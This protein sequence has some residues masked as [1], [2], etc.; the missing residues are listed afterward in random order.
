MFFFFFGGKG[1][2]PKITWDNSGSQGF[3]YGF[4]AQ[5]L[6]SCE[7]ILSMVLLLE[8]IPNNHLGC[9]KSLSI[10][11]CTISTGDFTGF[12]NH[13]P[14][15]WNKPLFAVLQ[16]NTRAICRTEGFMDRHQG[17][18]VSWKCH[19]GWCVEDRAG[20]MLS[21][22]TIWRVKRGKNGGKPGWLIG[23]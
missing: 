22:R 18:T 11:I 3:W 4:F 13:Q 6:R 2:L 16:T 21:Q 12:L 15:L 5:F 10:W 9:I 7:S 20:P 8:E 17:T 14:Y 23:L 1:R 19:L